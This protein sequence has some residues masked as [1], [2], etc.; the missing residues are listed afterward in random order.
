MKRL[1][2][3]FAPVARWRLWWPFVLLLAL[4]VAGGLASIQ[5]W[6]AN[7]R[8]TEA[9]E[10]LSASQLRSRAQKLAQAASAPAAPSAPALSSEQL[11]WRSEV[12]KLAQFDLNG[13]LAQIES[14]QVAGVRA[15]AIE[16]DPQTQS[17]TIE[18]EAPSLSEVLSYLQ[19][20]NADQTRWRWKLDHA[21]SAEG[22]EV[23]RL[24]G[25]QVT[26]RRG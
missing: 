7:V 26:S 17:A 20:L 10:A 14:A 5:A 22:I 13:V 11:R 6:Q 25:V 19:A 8:L 23:A 1:D 4:L 21:V 2:V 16:V 3:D 15:R 24:H 9:Q 12:A 18:I